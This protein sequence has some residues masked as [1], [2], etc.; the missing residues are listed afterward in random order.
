MST[1]RAI[2]IKNG[3][4]PASSL[5]LNTNIPKP[6]PGL[7]QALV[8]IHSFG[9]NRMDLMQR[10]GK[11]NVPPQ[12]GKTLGVEFSGWIVELGDGETGD[13]VVGDEVF[14]LA[15]G[16]AYAEY[17]ATSTKMLI[18]KPK[19]I[20]WTVAAGIPETWITATQALH[21]VGC[22][23]PGD[24]VLW[25]AGASSVS[26]AGIQLARANGASKIFVTA[27]SDEKVEFCKTLGATA[28]FN[29][30]TQN[31]VSGIKAATDGHGVD[32]IVDFIG[33]SYSQGNLE[34]AAMDGRIV[35]LASLGGS[36][37]GAGLDIGLLE[38]KR[39]RWEGSR[40]RSRGLDYQSRL[41]DLLVEFAVPRFVDGTFQVPVEKVFSWRDIQEAHELMESNQSKGK[42][43][44][45]VE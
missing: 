1:M 2:D 43:I 6:R 45:S 30:H 31:W 39:L 10:E 5:F 26:I 34:V 38:N 16:G 8:K 7:S 24:N 23:K 28:G 25:H 41:R 20:S 36:K 14:G 33:G 11:Y 37:L 22:F 42:I 4:G 15:Y 13:F 3:T 21:L 9:L 32:V 40:L 17:L 35:Q 44:C 18:H 19:E 12:A 29:Y 27:G